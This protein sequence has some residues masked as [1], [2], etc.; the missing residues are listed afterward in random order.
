MKLVCS[1]E[2]ALSFYSEQKAKLPSLRV[3]LM[4]FGSIM[5][6]NE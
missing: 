5:H 4:F 6:R 3:K 1:R 2:R